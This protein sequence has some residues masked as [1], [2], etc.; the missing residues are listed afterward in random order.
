MT[1]ADE[2][3]LPS[4]IVAC[5]HSPH[6]PTHVRGRGRGPAG[7]T[8]RRT[9]RS[10]RVTA[11]SRKAP[12][13]APH[14]PSDHAARQRLLDAPT[15]CPAALPP[16]GVSARLGSAEIKRARSGRAGRGSTSLIS[17]AGGKGGGV[18]RRVP[19]ARDI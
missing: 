3:K 9:S 12:P 13:P 2:S 15:V 18:A 6:Q 11:M 14:S 19:P 4:L 1:R 8:A 5:M 10:G 7:P 16:A 17:R